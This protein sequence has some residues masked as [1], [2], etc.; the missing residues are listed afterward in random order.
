[1]DGVWLLSRGAWRANF[2][3]TMY[4]CVT[5]VVG[6]GREI[7]WCIRHA[8]DVDGFKLALLMRCSACSRKSV[9]DSLPPLTIHPYHDGL[10]LLSNLALKSLISAFASSTSTPS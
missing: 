10:L 1:M 8:D 3:C 9:D 7:G 4:G 5:N 6:A 2:G